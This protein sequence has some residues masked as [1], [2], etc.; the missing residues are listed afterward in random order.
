MKLLTK[1]ENKRVATIYG[2]ILGAFIILIATLVLLSCASMVS[3]RETMLEVEPFDIHISE[4]EVLTPE[5]CVSLNRIAIM[6]TVK[7]K[8]AN[9]VLIA[10]PH[11]QIINRY[12]Y[13][14]NGELIGW[15]LDKELQAKDGTEQYIRETIDPSSTTWLIDILERLD[16]GLGPWES[17]TEE[18]KP[19]K[20]EEVVIGI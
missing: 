6:C 4:I 12:C 13:L 20:M 17:D 9:V 11:L 3:E 1:L 14:E 8:K 7:H 10:T 15:E 5:N 18:T 16:K 2:I 19:E